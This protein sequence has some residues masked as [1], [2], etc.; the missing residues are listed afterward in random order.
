MDLRLLSNNAGWALLTFHSLMHRIGLNFLILA[1]ISA[2]TDHIDPIDFHSSDDRLTHLYIFS[3][4]SYLSKKI[5]KVCHE[6][7]N[8]RSQKMIDLVL[9][10][11]N[12]LVA[13]FL[14]LLL[15]NLWL[16]LLKDSSKVSFL[17]RKGILSSFSTQFWDNKAC[18]I[19]ILRPS[20][21]LSISSLRPNYQHQHQSTLSVIDIC[22]DPEL[23]QRL[24]GKDFTYLHIFPW[25]C[26]SITLRIF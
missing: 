15:P 6:K 8:V 17:R 9:Y 26:Y 21:K 4:S 20:S 7:R 11:D 5:S 12:L 2:F 16:L 18:Y 24:L 3:Y 23:F 19:F 1:F 10:R 22:P 25:N 14:L 13:L